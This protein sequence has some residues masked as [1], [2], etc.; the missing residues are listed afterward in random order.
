MKQTPKEVKDSVKVGDR[1]WLRMPHNGTV[2]KV[3]GN[4]VAV[5]LDPIEEG[6]TMERF[7]FDEIQILDAQ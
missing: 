1:V 6:S 2:S 7:G 4:G 3:F 5:D